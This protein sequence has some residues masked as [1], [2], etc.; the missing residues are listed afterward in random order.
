MAL[1]VALDRRR[2]ALAKGAGPVSWF[3]WAIGAISI[4]GLL[5]LAM[6]LALYWPEVKREGETTWHWWAGDQGQMSWTDLDLLDVGSLIAILIGGVF[7]VFSAKIVYGLF[8]RVI[9]PRT[10]LSGAA[11]LVLLSVAYS[12]PLYE[13]EVAGLLRDSGLSTL[14]VSVAEISVEASLSSQGT[15]GSDSARGQAT[16]S[17][18]LSIARVTDP[19]PGIEA[20]KA[21]FGA[22]DADE[23]NSRTDE[24]ATNVI[25]S[26]FNYIGRF[27][28][29]EDRDRTVKSSIELFLGPVTSLAECL[30]DYTRSIPDSQLLL[31]D[32]KPAIA[33]LFKIHNKITRSFSEFVESGSVADPFLQRADRE[34]IREGIRQ[35][36]DSTRL[37]MGLGKANTEVCHPLPAES[38]GH[39]RQCGG[40]SV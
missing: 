32:V 21:D 25:E 2:V 33:N 29:L 26:D 15:P 22:Q 14:K 19:T 39:V 6:R 9:S 34:D 12:L 17:P 38:K 24:K 30:K 8:T 28:K 3:P 37:T 20:L 23:Q 40:L 18:S 10:A 1:W 16:G 36:I 31:I 11:A 5:M 27:E 4:C 7:G 13:R 35:T